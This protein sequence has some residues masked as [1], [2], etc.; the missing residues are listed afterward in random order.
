M[1]LGATVHHLRIELSDVDRGVYQALDLRVARHPSETMTY[2]VTRVL[3]Y[4]LLYEEGIGFSHGLSATNEP[5][6]WIKDLQGNLRAWI[7][8]GAPGAD[9]LHRAAKASP[10]VAIVTAMKPEL[11]VRVG[12]E[13]AIHRAD[14]IEVHAIEPGFVAALEAA[15]DRNTRWELVRSGGEL[16]ATVSGQTISGK[17][18]M[19]QLAAF[20]RS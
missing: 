18:T 5:A 14:A 20:E 8:V 3:G 11:V 12:R 15:T 7:E 9:R 19:H 13:R 1:A 6:L 17:I 4:C 10:R 2:L 16:Y